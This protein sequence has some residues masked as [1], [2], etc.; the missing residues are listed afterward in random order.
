MKK[1]CYAVAKRA[2]FSLT[3]NCRVGVGTALQTSGVIKVCPATEASGGGFLGPQMIDD[4][5]PS[6]LT[7]KDTIIGLVKRF[8]IKKLSARGG[9]ERLPAKI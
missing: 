5:R 2:G 3:P 7:G 9:H 1:L 4:L 8:G 6:A